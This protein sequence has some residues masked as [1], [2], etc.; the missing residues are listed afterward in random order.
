M[1]S[2]LLFLGFLVVLTSF[3]LTRLSSCSALPL[4]PGP[5][6]SWLGAIKL[7]RV[8]PWRTYAEWK[9]IYG[10]LIYIYV[11][12]NPVLILNSASAVSDL[13]EKRG[14][15]YSSRP[16]RTMVSDLMGW[17]WMFSSMKYGPAWKQHR[18]LFLKHFPI[19]TT[20]PFHPLQT[21]EAHVLLRNLLQS[22]DKFHFHTRRAAAAIILQITYGIQINE[23][24]DEY[25]DNYVSLADKAMSTLAQAGL[26]GTYMVDYLPILK[27]I[28]P[29]LPGASFKRLAFQ[30]R[31]LTL[32]MLNRPF[33]LVKQKMKDGI[34]SPSIVASE[35]EDIASGRAPHENERILK[36]VA[37]TTYAAGSDTTVSVLMS[38]FLAM[39]LHPEIQDKAQCQLDQVL[40]D[41]LPIFED[42]QQLP[43][44]DCICYELLRWN[45]VTPLGLN[46]FVSEDD[47]YKGYRIPK[48]TTVLPNVWA[49]LHDPEIYP[50]PL[51][52]NPD[53]F[54]NPEKNIA[55]GI[56]E[57]PDAAF[58]F[59]RRMCP[60]RWLAFDSIWIAVASILTVFRI[61][62]AVDERGKIIE[63]QVEYASLLISHP[64]PF[65]CSI[66]PRSST[67]VK[68]IQQTADQD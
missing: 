66:T 41:R 57:I 68:L 42:R 23:K 10:D 37:A 43:Y 63:P 34:A 5:K 48:G 2:P 33:D 39:A 40:N 49:I 54:Q 52:F 51:A 45:P 7:P 14:G 30:W 16:V 58:G 35:L 13:L 55:Q 44:I 4:P 47:E 9:N 36:N 29:W 62:K 6:S 46:H 67:T 56:N 26:F 3:V 53:R 38:L 61:S 22:P 65:Q 31:K 64:K 19:N 59:G 21:K 18:K 1:F 60:G 32:E 12:G 15:N 50:D 28:P 25:G 24:V 8:Y 11:L 17:N 27:Y 20:T